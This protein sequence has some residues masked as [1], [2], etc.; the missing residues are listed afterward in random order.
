[1]MNFEN[2]MKIRQAWTTFTGNHPKFPMFLKAVQREGIKEG[3]I[4]EVSIT[5]PDGRR[6]DTNIKVTE[7]D[8]Q[9]F[10]TLKSMGNQ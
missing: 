4:V 6:M 5:T 2:I 9:L 7:S 1:M 8:L 3:T 10:D